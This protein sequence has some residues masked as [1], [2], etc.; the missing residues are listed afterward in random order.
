MPDSAERN[1]EVVRE[2]LAVM[3]SGDHERMGRFVNEM[4][5]PEVE[6]SPRVTAVEGATYEGRDGLARFFADFTESFEVTYS[7]VELR[8]ISDH[9]VLEL[10]H[11]E[12][13][14]QGSG[15]DVSQEIA[16]V[17]EFEDGLMRRGHVYD[18]HAEGKAAAAALE[19]VDA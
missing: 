1:C 6:W 16:A 2:A 15:V 18:S 17:F 5:H 7:D 10:A 8:P 3:E 12:F 19:R 4:A 14:G 9:A 11:A 13:R